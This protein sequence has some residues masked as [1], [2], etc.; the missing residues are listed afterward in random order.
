MS[1]CFAG[2]KRT[3]DVDATL[4][5]AGLSKEVICWGRSDSDRSLLRKG[6]G[7]ELVHS[8]R[9]SLVSSVHALL[10]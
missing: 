4:L 10:R 3:E 9:S 5:M 2:L 6:Q 7:G 1:Y 8:K